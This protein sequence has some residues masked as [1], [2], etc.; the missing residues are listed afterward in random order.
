[1]TDQ[2]FQSLTQFYSDSGIKHGS[3]VYV[4]ADMGKM[5][6][7]ATE[8][9]RKLL[10]AHFDAIK[11]LIGEKGTIVV[12]TASLNL[13]NTDIVFNPETTPSSGMGAF[14]EFVRVQHGA[15]RSFH[16]F[17]SVAA[18]GYNACELVQDISRH[19]FGYNSI[20]TRLI[21]NDCISLH[22]GVH[23]RFSFSLIHYIE[24][25]SGVPYRYTKEF[26]HPVFRNGEVSLEPFYHFA[27][28]KNADLN[29]DK[30]IRIYKWFESNFQVGEMNFSRGKIWCY[31]MDDFFS[32]VSR[33]FMQDI[34]CWL[35]TEPNIRPYRL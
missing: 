18:V 1:M 7:S 19:A 16:P 6:S 13:C 33:L 5:L 4:S 17:W 31:P 29:R 20:W 8:D 35:S 34:Y 15:V 32:I 21:E 26:I 30:N 28:Y 27:C 12:P 3:T 24:L 23:P 2:N 11:S 22:L 10:W 9:R 25:L 14:S